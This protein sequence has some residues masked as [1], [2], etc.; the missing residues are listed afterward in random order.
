M[1]FDESGK[2]W[3]NGEL[4]DWKDA[5]IH[6]LSHVVHYGSSVFEGLRCYDTEKGPAVFR[7]KDHMKRL[8]NSAKVY[9]MDIPYTLDELCDAVK[10]TIKEDTEEKPSDDYFKPSDLSAVPNPPTEI[11]DNNQEISEKP[12]EEPVDLSQS[13][14]N[15]IDEVVDKPEEISNDQ[16]YTVEEATEK[17]R[18]LVDDLRSHGVSINADEMNFPKSYQVIIKIEI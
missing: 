6:V 5:Q 7:L 18:N 8:L 15:P 16:N 2:I 10:E 3:F 14:I 1:A 13:L 12:P 11:E 17:I 9:R 4:V